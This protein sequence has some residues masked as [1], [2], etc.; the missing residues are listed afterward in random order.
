MAGADGPLYAAGGGDRGARRRDPRR[1]VH[2]RRRGPAPD[3][4]PHR[5]IPP[6]N[7]RSDARTACGSREGRIAAVESRTGAG[8][9][10]H[11]SLPPGA[12]PGAGR[13]RND[14]GR[15]VRTARRGD[16][17]RGAVYPRRQSPALLDGA[18][19]RPAGPD[20]RMPRGNTLH[21]VRPR[22]ADRTRNSLCGRPLR[23][24]PR[25]RPR[26][27]AGRG[28]HGLR[29]GEHSARRQDFRSR[30][31]LRHQGQ[32]AGR[33]SRR[34]RGPARGAFGGAGA[35]RRRRA[36]RIRRR[37]PAVAGRTR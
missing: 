6:R 18:D 19:A 28:G 21:A 24:G 16:R 30:Q 11:R 15:Q 1:G 17:P 2:G 7:V 34:R 23:R 20:R 26:R 33:R 12:A 32:T 22:R 35:G 27:G 36:A 31:P 10:Q 29:N 13:G 5:R 9:G 25:L 4:P 37:R 3:R 14:A 8:E